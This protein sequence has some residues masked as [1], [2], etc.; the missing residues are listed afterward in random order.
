MRLKNG[1]GLF[2][3]GQHPRGVDGVLLRF[4]V[5]RF[6][7]RWPKGEAPVKINAAERRCL[8]EKIQ[9]VGSKCFRDGTRILRLARK[10]EAGHDARVLIEAG[11]FWQPPQRALYKAHRE[12]D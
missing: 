6:R 11:T 10:I 1:R 5:E 9:T 7:L 4:A 12:Y 8:V 3:I 2:Q